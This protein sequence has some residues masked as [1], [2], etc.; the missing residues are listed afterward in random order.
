MA[1]FREVNAALIALFRAL[2][3]NYPG[4][5]LEPMEHIIES[6]FYK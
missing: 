6:R 4:G 5:N 3:L 2:T 1:F